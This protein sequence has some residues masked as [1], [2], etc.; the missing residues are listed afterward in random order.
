M[1]V[2]ITARKFKARDTLKEFIEGEIES[3][4]KNNDDIL[5]VEVV[6]SFQNALNSVKQAELLVK[7]P[8]QTLTAKDESDEF[9]KSVKI[10]IEKVI[11]QLQKLKDKRI[12][13]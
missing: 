9:E 5:D 4:T 12:N 7:V 10:A 13:H 8:G 3:L 2:T 11:R 1:K 6:L